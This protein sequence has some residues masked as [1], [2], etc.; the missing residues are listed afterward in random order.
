[1]TDFE[2]F[3]KAGLG[4]NIPPEKCHVVI[5][6]IQKGKDEA[7]ALRFYFHYSVMRWRNKKRRLIKDW[8]MH[9]WE[10]IWNRNSSGNKKPQN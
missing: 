1:M 6:F 2:T 8:K 3:Q 5:Y 10:W 9:A 4:S 7:E